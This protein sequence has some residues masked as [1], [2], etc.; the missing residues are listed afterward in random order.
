MSKLPGIR[1]IKN[2]GG[3]PT[4]LMIDIA[5]N[6]QLVEDFLDVIEAK[7]RA[8]EKTIPFDAV[9]RKLDKKHGIRR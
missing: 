2:A 4:T 6:K 8:K 3:E 9:I 5:K 1:I 7:K